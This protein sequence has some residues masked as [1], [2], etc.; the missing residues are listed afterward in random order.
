MVN[1]GQLTSKQANDI[2]VAVAQQADAQQAANKQTEIANAIDPKSAEGK[3]KI[4]DAAKKAADDI[5][6]L[7]DSIDKLI[8]TQFSEQQAV[9]A[10][11]RDMNTIVDD[12]KAFVAAGGNMAN[13]MSGTSNE[14]LALQDDIASL[15][16]SNGDLIKVWV[17]QGITG[18]DL[19]NRVNVLAQGAYQL[20]IAQGFPKE[21]AAKLR[22]TLLSIPSAV[23]TTVQVPGAF[24]ATLNVADLQNRLNTLGGS[25]AYPWVQALI[26]QGSFQAAHD[27]INALAVTRYARVIVQQTVQKIQGIFGFAGGGIIAAAAGG[28][29]DSG[30]RPEIAA[31]GT[32]RWNEPDTH[33]EAYIPFAGDW[34]RP[35]AQSVWL[36]AGKRI[37]MLNP[38]PTA[39]TRAYGGGAPGGQAG[40]GSPAS[41]GHQSNNTFQVQAFDPREAA[42][43]MTREA[44]WAAKTAH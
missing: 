36:E 1:S 28:R 12:A 26:D 33:G 30:R 27:A 40:E 25:K 42:L 43:A 23:S 34:R 13:V 17:Q 44:R 31:A 4:G 10:L 2:G 35:A 41:I 37:G 9:T 24:S 16:Q 39:G 15:A 8:G 3:Q 14:A 38:S 11:H 18:T 7:K 5:D 6:A 22:D 20:A 19:A 21:A 32:V 29:I